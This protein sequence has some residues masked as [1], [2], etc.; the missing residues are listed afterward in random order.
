MPNT[1][2]LFKNQ[3]KGIM[4]RT[5][6]RRIYKPKRRNEILKV[7][8]ASEKKLVSMQKTWDSSWLL[9]ADRRL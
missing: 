3:T 5:C 9:T 8:K 1:T 2:F 4:G 7:K 6:H